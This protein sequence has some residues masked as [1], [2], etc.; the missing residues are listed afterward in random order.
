MVNHKS[1]A[2]PFKTI[3]FSGAQDIDETNI[4]IGPWCDLLD[5]KKGDFSRLGEDYF[6]PYADEKRTS[7]A[8]EKALR[9]CDSFVHHLANELNRLHGKRYSERYWRT[10]LTPSIISIIEF[11]IFKYDILD[12]YLKDDKNTYLIEAYSSNEHPM[13]VSTR[14]LLSWLNS[15]TGVMYV[16][17]QMVHILQ[18]KNLII[19][20]ILK[21]PNKPLTLR[22]KF[23]LIKKRFKEKAKIYLSIII[24]IKNGVYIYT[25]TG[26][27]IKDVFLL[28]I[29]GCRLKLRNITLREKSI[30]RTDKYS[31]EEI[32]KNFTTGDVL[33]KIVFNI[34]VN[35]LP[36]IYFKSYLKNERSAYFPAYLIS[37]FNSTLVC[38][39]VLGGND[40]AK[41][42]IERCI[43]Y[44]C[45][46]V[47][48]QHGSN[49]GTAAVFTT[50]RAIEYKNSD[51]FITWGW[52]HH[53]NYEL[54]TDVLPVPSLSKLKYMMQKKD[55]NEI[56]FLSNNLSLYGDRITSA[57]KPQQLFEYFSAKLKFLQ[58][59]SERLK[60]LLKYKPY[61]SKGSGLIPEEK[62][63][64]VKMPDINLTN[65]KMARYVGISRLLVIDHPGTAMFERLVLNKPLIMFWEDEFWQMS[66][67]SKPFFQQ[68]YEAGVLY[69]SPVDAADFINK[70]YNNCEAWWESEKVQSAVKIFLDNYALTSKDY[71]DNWSDYL[72]SIRQQY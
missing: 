20:N 61:P 9:Y 2:H 28:K 7:D 5:F 27:N 1:I 54:D 55:K 32:V 52:K 49:Y 30:I 47:V 12:K 68:L 65:D 67:Q 44:G 24:S 31:K 51:R 17:S 14:D 33:E 48:N 40:T 56:I 35:T 16:Y 10:I 66:K 45:K 69:Y 70:N 38:G 4:K 37:K 53:S 8:S 3:I 63:V 46:L 15:D 19:S 62:F 57:P 41:F 26:F 34:L 42:D 60:P 50:M 13:L 59:L 29:S 72:C 58:L 23:L 71:L 6:N 21:L 18:P 25:I 36:D 39:P 43:E 11:V 64:K 22:S